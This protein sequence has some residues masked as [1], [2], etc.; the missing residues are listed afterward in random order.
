MRAAGAAAAVAPPLRRRVIRQ[1]AR[2][3][4]EAPR[5]RRRR[6]PREEAADLAVAL[7]ERAR[8]PPH[9]AR[10]E[11]RDGRPVEPV[12]GPAP[13]LRR[14]AV[15]RRRRLRGHQISDAIDTMLDFH[16]AHHSAGRAERE[17]AAGLR[18]PVPAR[19]A[20]AEVSGCRIV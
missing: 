17:D 5:V 19:E 20:R 1:G 16:T 8:A 14:V 18:D 11:L 2:R 3:R 13:L 15:V 7:G 12:R 9:A 4:R 6:P 10:Q